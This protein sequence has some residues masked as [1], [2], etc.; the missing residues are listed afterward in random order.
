MSHPDFEL[1][2]NV[3]R[4]ADQITAARYGI[5]TRGDLLRWAKRDAKPFLSQHP[6]PEEPLPNP[7][8]APYLAALAAAETHAEFSAVTQ[9]LLDAAEPVLRAVS[10]YLFAAAQW[11]GQHRGAAKGSP[12]KL[13]MEAASRSLSVAAIADEADLTTLRAVYDPAPSL[14]LPPPSQARAS[15]GFPPAPPHAPPAGP[16]PGR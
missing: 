15:S 7:D 4:D 11:R 1:Y 5:A 14:N 12:P 6:L 3:G 13:L 2:D 10:D 8:L 9:R 16:R